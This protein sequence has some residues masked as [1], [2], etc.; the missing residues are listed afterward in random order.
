[1][2]SRHRDVPPCRET[3]CTIFLPSSYCSTQAN[4]IPAFFPPKYAPELFVYGVSKLNAICHATR[5]LIRFETW[6][7][8]LRESRVFRGKFLMTY[9]H[10]I[11]LPDHYRVIVSAS[12]VGPTRFLFPFGTTVRNL[13][14]IR[15]TRWMVLHRYPPRILFFCLRKNRAPRY[16]DKVSRNLETALSCQGG[17]FELCDLL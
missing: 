9:A 11:A 5:R 1:M 10:V 8:S 3:S 6:L 13:V 14:Y 4:S 7:F 16:E 2:Y 15:T 17:F 12:A